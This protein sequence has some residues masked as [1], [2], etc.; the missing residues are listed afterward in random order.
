MAQIGTQEEEEKPL[1]ASLQK[2]QS[3]ETITLEETLKLFELPRNL[4][5][6]R[7]KEVIIGV[8]RFG[9]YV[10]H[11]N[12]FVSLPK[13]TDPLE[14]T[15]EESIELIE[16]K[17][18]KDREKIIRTFEEEPGLQVLNGRY[19]PYIAF[20]KSNYKIPKKMIPAE[21]TLEECRTIIAEAGQ[22]KTG[23]GKTGKSS[24]KG[25][26]GKTE[27]TKATAKESTVKKRTVKSTA[28]KSAT[29]KTAA[30]K[31]AA[32]KPKA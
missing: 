13:G 24:S 10:R 15:L 16:A 23:K 9:P 25:S 2:T 8:G 7:E 1:F 11:D 22:G 4:G 29:G 20:E 6:F 28:G 27:T 12:K 17:E 18:K 32:K 19:G 5:G 30:K 26:T 3:I 14:I 31:P 21:L